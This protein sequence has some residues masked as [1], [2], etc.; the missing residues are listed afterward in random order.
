MRPLLPFVPSLVHALAERGIVIGRAGFL[1]DLPEQLGPKGSERVDLGLLDAISLAPAGRPRLGFLERGRGETEAP[2]LFD[3]EGR[4]VNLEPKAR[5]KGLLECSEL[6]PDRDAIW[7][8][9]GSQSAIINTIISRPSSAPVFAIV[10]SKV[11]LI[12]PLGR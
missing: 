4:G 10:A 2:D 9:A 11:S 5:V 1:D 7:Y 6:V 3:R 8:R 12:S